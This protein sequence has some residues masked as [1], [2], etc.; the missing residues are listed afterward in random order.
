VGLRGLSWAYRRGTLTALK[1]LSKTIFF[2]VVACLVIVHGAFAQ[3]PVLAV[4][5]QTILFNYTTGSNATPIQAVVVSAAS[6]T[7]PATV[8]STSIAYNPGDPTNW[9]LIPSPNGAPG[10][11]VPASFNV[12]LVNT[13]ALAPGSYGAT[14]TLNYSGADP[15]S[16]NTIAVSLTVSAPGGGGGSGNPN[17][18]ITATPSNLSFS[19]APGGGTPAPQAVIVLVN[20]GA[21]FTTAAVTTDGNPW[22]SASVGSDGMTVTVNVNPTMLSAGS[23][24]GTLTFTAPSAVVQVPVTLAVSGIGLTVN[25]AQLT[26]NIPQNYGFGA[27]QTIQ[28]SSMPPAPIMAFA[29]SDNNWLV[30]DTPTAQTPAT[31]S[32]RA[33]DSSLPQG[34][35]AGTVTVETSP[36]NAVTLPV[37]LNVGPPATLSLAPGSVSFSYTMGNPA[38][39]FQTA[40]V[41]SLSGAAQTFSVTSS[42]NDGAAW[43]S[44]TAATPTTPGTVNIS[45]NPAMLAAGSYSGVVNVM[46]S[47]TGSSAQPIS[48]SLN[49]LPPPTPVVNAVVSASNYISGAVAPGEFVTLFG[50][51]LGPAALTTPP[52]GTFPTTLGGTSVTFSGLPAPI[53]YTSATQMTVQV[54]YGI[55]IG[56]TL[57]SVQRSGVSSTLMPINSVPAMPSFFTADSSGKG[58]IAALNQDLSVNSPSNPA[59]RGSVIVL[60]GTGEGAT[61]PASVEGAITP[62]APPFPQTQLPILVT[63]QGAPATLQYYGETPGAVSGLLQINALIPATSPTGPAV[64]V[65]ISINGQT[66]PGGV[67]VAIK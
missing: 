30:L 61:V 29:T 59:T 15:S 2:V 11:S 32:L 35:Y 39:A 63:F 46:P 7:G 66:S 44:A 16:A 60:Y 9:L 21:A 23:Y 24:T 25:P 34:T 28:V 67:T 5:P 43:L 51:A 55:A 52:P 6:G 19:Y 22:L 12:Y 64:P 20:D 62:T 10:L 3:A 45:V 56:Q 53:L 31:I 4:S 36:G 48:V 1:S 13:A 38:P 40:A 33:N 37:T 54:P 27:T 65:L 50:A 14:I 49:V 47:A 41:K 18:T 17:E 8:L 58:Q 57:L 42:T 26:F